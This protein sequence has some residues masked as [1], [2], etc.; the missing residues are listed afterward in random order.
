MLR[1]MIP[2]DVITYIDKIW[3]PNQDDAYVILEKNS[4]LYL[5]LTEAFEYFFELTPDEQAENAFDVGPFI[6]IHPVG[7]F[8]NEYDPV[9][10]EFLFDYH[11]IKHANLQA[12]HLTI[13]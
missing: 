12:H 6:G 2:D 10:Y 13:D 9:R 8:Q 11:D 3:K 1:D 7:I 4:K 5:E